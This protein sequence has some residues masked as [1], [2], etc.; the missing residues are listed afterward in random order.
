MVSVSSREDKLNER[1]T[2]GNKITVEL[3]TN[4]SIE[5]CK[6]DIEKITQV[7]DL[8]PYGTSVYIPALPK[9][10]LATSIPCIARLYEAGYDPVPHIA[11]RRIPSRK[12][13]QEYLDKIVKDYGVHRVLLI[14]GDIPKPIGPYKDSLAILKDGILEYTGIR[15]IGIA[16]YPENHPRIPADVLKIAFEEKLELAAKTGLA[17]YIVTQFC[18]SPSHIVDYCAALA[19]TN[20]NTPVYVGMAGPTD[21][22]KLF[23]YARICGVSASILGLK[24]LGFKAV[25]LVSHTEPNE[26]LAVLAKYCAARD[27]CNVIGVH[28]FSFGSIVESA[29]W[30]HSKFSQVNR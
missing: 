9:Q 27:R 21:L 4:G 26:Q 15:E 29:R 23:R 13:L 19:H 11:A 22:A 17:S 25:Q 1:D 6:S 2:G 8:L 5:L 14:G 3:V 28:I 18:F 7:K 24:S 20:P 16:G 10:N 12:E 30:M